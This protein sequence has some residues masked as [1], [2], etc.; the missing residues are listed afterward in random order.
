MSKKNITI[1]SLG[2][3]TTAIGVYKINSYRTNFQNSMI[4][5]AEFSSNAT[6]TPYET[7]TQLV[8]A[9][10]N[11]SNSKG[12]GI[13]FVNN[14]GFSAAGYSNIQT[15][16]A[17]VEGEIL[18][19]AEI[20]NEKYGG[21]TIING[22]GGTSEGIGRVYELPQSKELIEKLRTLNVEV[23]H[24]AAV[25]SN[26]A[27]YGL[28]SNV[29]YAALIQTNDPNDWNARNS[30]G[31]SSVVELSTAA[32]LESLKEG[33]KVEVAPLIVREGGAIGMKEALS[34]LMELNRISTEQNI[35]IEKLTQKAPLII[36]VGIQ[37]G[38][39]PLELIANKGPKAGTQL[40]TALQQLSEISSDFKKLV[41]GS[42]IRVEFFD[43]NSSTPKNVMTIS[44]SVNKG[45]S[46]DNAAL[47]A[48]NQD[49]SLSTVNEKIAQKVSAIL[50]HFPNSS[51]A[52]IEIKV[53]L[54]PA[55]ELN[56]LRD[57][58]K[59]LIK[60]GETVPREVIEKIQ[61]HNEILNSKAYT[62]AL[63]EVTNELLRILDIYKEHSSELFRA[64]AISGELKLGS[65]IKN[66]MTLAQSE[67]GRNLS[68][69]F[70]GSKFTA[71]SQVERA[72][73][74]VLKK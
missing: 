44:S 66:A 31:I 21:G 70:D 33:S 71:P 3:L 36:Q 37:P 34:Y 57:Q 12:G 17:I 74:S 23:V 40:L 58:V 41:E 47:Y 26:A 28:H 65:I 42:G 73:R 60:N 22:A 16:D 52:E 9:A 18:K 43:S 38:N 64:K 39:E 61:L 59:A 35:P 20:L 56:T 19:Y 54:I 53:G 63:S 55:A 15:F 69:L 4:E 8:E 67:K 29:K 46:I 48:M 49:R 32:L 27:R 50:T 62:Q 30:K 72:L 6:Y 11:Y 45:V 1:L 7:S 24:T 10:I 2:L 14:I 51:S 13:V 68:L 25:S 5:S